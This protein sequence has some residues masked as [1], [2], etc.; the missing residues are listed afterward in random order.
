M[1]I[2]EKLFLTLNWIIHSIRINMV[3]FLFCRININSCVPV[4][5]CLSVCYH[6]SSYIP[7]LYVEIKVVLSFLC[8]FLYVH[9]CGFG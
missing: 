6:T 1:R 8:R 9:M 5:L 2:H 7:H 4:S 3:A